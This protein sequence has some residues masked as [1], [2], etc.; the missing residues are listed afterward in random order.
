[1]T[2]GLNLLCPSPAAE[3]LVVRKEPFEEFPQNRQREFQ[4]V[5]G[6]TLSSSLLLFYQKISKKQTNFSH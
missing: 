3:Q 5:H 6:I 4:N 2:D 1:M